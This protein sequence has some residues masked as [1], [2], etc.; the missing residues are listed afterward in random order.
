V[1]SC[2]NLD[3]TIF[4]HTTVIARNYSEWNAPC[5]GF[6]AGCDNAAEK[7][8]KIYLLML[9]IGALLAA[10]HFTSAREEGSKSL[11]Q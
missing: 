2:R 7:D 6:V 5:I 1:P 11:P 4:Y 9:L 8:M 3:L 10:T